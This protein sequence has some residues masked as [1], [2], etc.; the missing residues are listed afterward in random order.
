MSKQDGHRVR[1]QLNATAASGSGRIVPRAPWQIAGESFRNSHA[2]VARFASWNLL[3]RRKGEAS[4]GARI[5]LKELPVE[6][7]E[8]FLCAR[9]GWM[10][11]PALKGALT[12]LLGIMHRRSVGPIAFKR[13]LHAEVQRKL[14]DYRYIAELLDQA[15]E[16]PAMDIL[17]EMDV[18]LRA[19]SNSGWASITE[20]GSSLM[21]KIT[22]PDVRSAMDYAMSLAQLMYLGPRINLLAQR[23]DETRPSFCKLCWRIN[24]VEQACCPVHSASKRPRNSTPQIADVFEL[25]RNGDSYFFSRRLQP[26][27]IEVLGKLDRLDRKYGV[28][29]RLRCALDERRSL[30]WLEDCRP[31]VFSAFGHSLSEVPPDGN[32]LEWLSVLDFVPDESESKRNER[33]NLHR[34]LSHSRPTL[35]NVVQRVEAW[36]IAA[37]IRRKRWGGARPKS[38]R[39]ASN[40]IPR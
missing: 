22:L 30:E 26:V 13:I 5:S 24:L 15:S 10:R 35:F 37:L 8:V 18:F 2:H 28:R 14:D 27:F 16:I 19:R 38:G 40:A 4:S 1:T 11:V 23:G 6:T 39:K 12:S 33:A 17:S 32:F 7:L 31:R 20:Y 29:S 9:F 3:H 36:L 25:A 21:A 34:V